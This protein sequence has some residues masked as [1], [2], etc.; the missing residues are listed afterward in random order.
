MQSIPSTDASAVAQ[1]HVTAYPT[2]IL[3]KNGVEVGNN[4]VYPNIDASAILAQINAG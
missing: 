2:V 3:L 4:W 1:Y